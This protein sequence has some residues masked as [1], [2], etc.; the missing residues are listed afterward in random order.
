MTMRNASKTLAIFL[1]FS[2]W[3]SITSAKGSEV[4]AGKKCPKSGAVMTLDNKKYTC[5]KSGTKLLWNKGMT[6]KRT[7]PSP[8]P[9]PVSSQSVTPTSRPSETSSKSPTSIKSFNLVPTF[10]MTSYSERLKRYKDRPDGYLYIEQTR[11]TVQILLPGIPN[12]N[13]ASEYFVVIRG[14]SV[15]NRACKSGELSLPM[16]LRAERDEK[17][18][19]GSLLPRSPKGFP[20][21]IIFKVTAFPISF[22]CYYSNNQTKHSLSV[23]ETVDL[24]TKLI[25]QSEPVEFTTPVMWQSLPPKPTPTP[26]QIETFAITPDAICLPEGAIVNSVDGRSYTCKKSSI[27]GQFRWSL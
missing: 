18:L 21:G 7:G 25:S 19:L 16:D 17:G 20:V 9:T 6:V 1:T 11:G 10:S 3:L 5:I 8:S 22:D 13:S 12:F 2:F 4:I 14:G 27:D 26:N 24:G 15:Y 23:I